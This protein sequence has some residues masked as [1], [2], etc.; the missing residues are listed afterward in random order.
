[1][2]RG[3]KVGPRQESWD[4]A[5]LLGG[6]CEL[7]QGQPGG[8][9]FW[10]TLRVRRRNTPGRKCACGRRQ[11]WVLGSVQRRTRGLLPQKPRAQGKE[12]QEM[13]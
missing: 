10:A 3:S 1:M 13:R 9:G 7:C 8:N 5:S 12:E 2:P 4:P 6:T 11:Q